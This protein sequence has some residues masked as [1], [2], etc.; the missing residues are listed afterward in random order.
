MSVTTSN[1]IPGTVLI[2]DKHLAWAKPSLHNANTHVDY[3]I[4]R[5]SQQKRP[6]A[7]GESLTKQQKVSL[8]LWSNVSRCTI[9]NSEA[10]SKLQGLAEI[11]SSM[12]CFWA[13]SAS[14]QPMAQGKEH[15]SEEKKSVRQKKQVFITT[16]K[17]R[18]FLFWV[19]CFVFFLLLLGANY[20]HLQLTLSTCIVSDSVKRFDVLV[21]EILSIF[22][23]MCMHAS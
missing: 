23:C 11:N 20:K 8:S 10:W 19:F 2:Q 12:P 6:T 14:I 9:S 4:P 1:S 5:V 17:H 18:V 15:D 3:V 21:N 13:L 22:Y 7:I 16:Q